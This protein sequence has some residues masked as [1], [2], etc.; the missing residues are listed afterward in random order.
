MALFPLAMVLAA[1]WV[2][3]RDDR[4]KFEERSAA[5]GGCGRTTRLRV[6]APARDTARRWNGEPVNPRRL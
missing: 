4:R 1:L 2:A 6:S 5:L 3:R